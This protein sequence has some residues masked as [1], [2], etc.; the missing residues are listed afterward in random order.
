MR[1]SPTENPQIS[2]SFSEATTGP[3]SAVTDLVRFQ[4]LA[5]LEHDRKQLDPR[6]RRR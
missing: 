3:N 5:S 4:R 6:N 2:Y 1:V